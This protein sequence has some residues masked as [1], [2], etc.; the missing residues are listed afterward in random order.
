[1]VKNRSMEHKML[2]YCLQQ[3]DYWMKTLRTVYPYGL[4][5]KT[6]FTNKYVPVDKLFSPMPRYGERFLN[7]T[8]RNNIDKRILPSDIS[9]FFNYIK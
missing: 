4:N 1:M 9:A 3:E 5:E 2:E 6:K 7:I 8:S